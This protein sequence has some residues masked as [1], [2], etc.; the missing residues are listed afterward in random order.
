MTSKY[1]PQGWPPKSSEIAF[2]AFEKDIFSLLN[3]I[4]IK[5]TKKAELFLFAKRKPVLC[6]MPEETDVLRP[7]YCNTISFKCKRFFNNFF[8][9]NR[10]LVGPIHHFKTVVAMAAIFMPGSTN[11]RSLASGAIENTKL[12]V[13]ILAT[14][15]VC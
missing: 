5:L 8:T 10:Y 7:F 14:S 4:T 2:V 13:L 3:S 9:G 6:F 12:I 1:G 15:T 11:P